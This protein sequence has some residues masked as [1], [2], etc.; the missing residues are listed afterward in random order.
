VSDGDAGHHGGDEVKGVGHEARPGHEG[1][2]GAHA[3]EAPPSAEQS[4]SDQKVFIDH[5]VGLMSAHFNDIFVLNSFCGQGGIKPSLVQEPVSRQI[6]QN[7][8][9]LFKKEKNFE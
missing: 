8:A 1:R 4:A 2:P 5:H 7:T 3:T 6:D 9:T